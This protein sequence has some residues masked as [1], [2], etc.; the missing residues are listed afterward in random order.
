MN[1]NEAKL[2]FLKLIQTLSVLTLKLLFLANM[3]S[4]NGHKCLTQLPTTIKFCQT[5]VYFKPISIG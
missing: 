2:L 5:Y 4:Q 3:L 1:E